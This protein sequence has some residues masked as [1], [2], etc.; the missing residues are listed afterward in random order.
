MKK[1]PSSFYIRR[2]IRHRFAQNTFLNPEKF[3]KLL[4]NH[5]IDISVRRLEKFEKEGWL[6][7]AFRIVLTKELQKESSLMID[8][9]LDVCY[10]EGLMEFPREGDYEPWDDFKR[11]Y[12]KGETYDRKLL[13]Y[14]PFQIMQVLTIIRFKRFSFYSDSDID[15]LAQNLVCNVR[16]VNQ[17]S[18]RAFSNKMKELENIIGF[19]M[20]LEEPYRFNVFG[21]MSINPLKPKN[22]IDLWHKWMTKKFS[23]RKLVQQYG[24]SAS[25]VWV[26]YQEIADHAY[27]T[28]PLAQWYDLTRIIKH[29][30]IDELKGKPL[31]A[32][33]YYRISRL[34]SRLYYDIT[35]NTLDEPD[36]TPSTLYGQWKTK[37]YSDPFDYATKKTQRGIIRFFVQEPTARIFLLVEGDTEQKIIEKIF[38]NLYVRMEDDG[39]AMLNCEGVGNIDKQKLDHII[40]MA[41]QDEI[42]VYVLADNEAKSRRKVKEIEEK[43]HTDFGSHIWKKS[44]EEDNFGRRKVIALINSYLSNHNKN[45]TDDEIMQ[46]QQNGAALVNA[47]EK[48]YRNKY[49]ESM[50]SVIRKTKPDISLE[51]FA[52]RL[53]KISYR[54][55]SGKPS[56]I[57]KVLDKVFKMV[58]TWR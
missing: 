37:V 52:P 34:L 10:K 50:W 23:A 20:V 49:R 51:L 32:Q 28:D 26:M 30:R 22:N 56:E 24:I 35:K 46:Q 27:R 55:K 45:L 7:P 3:S 33:F 14:H 53:K 29:Y 21:H 5:D 9:Q 6:R 44:F 16:N 42:S 19:L 47:I 58:S 17:S 1:R 31:T 41:N 18:E 40:K 43:V 15:K 39:I 2:K 8:T 13:Y 38:D 25:D 12:Q 57:E 48:A 36:I 4:K 54:K 11:D